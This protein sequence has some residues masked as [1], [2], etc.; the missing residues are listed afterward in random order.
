MR[1]TLSRLRGVT[2]EESVLEEAIAN[3]REATQRVRATQ[4]LMHS[5]GM[6][7]DVNYWELLTRLSTALA[8]TEAAY[9]EASSSVSFAASLSY[10]RTPP[11]HRL[12]RGGADR[13]GLNTPVGGGRF[14]LIRHHVDARVAGSY[15]VDH[16]VIGVGQHISG[17]VSAGAHGHLPLR[18]KR[19]NG[20]EVI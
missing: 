15:L 6:T 5:Q 20:L 18:A 3:L 19:G 4:N 16:D 14:V 8:I 17:D 12:R 9:V 1:C 11:V 13:G 2:K 10:C 7:Q